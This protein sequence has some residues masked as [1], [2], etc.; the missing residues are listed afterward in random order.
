MQ[1]NLRCKPLLNNADR[2]GIYIFFKKVI[3]IQKSN[4]DFYL[5]YGV[6]IINI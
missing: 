6:A 5:A 2:I 4:S 1:V 3:T